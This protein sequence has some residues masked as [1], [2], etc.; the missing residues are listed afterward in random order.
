MR[1]KNSTNIIFGLVLTIISFACNNK[2]PNQLG[3]ISWQYSEDKYVTEPDMFRK[4]PDNGEKGIL[5]LEVEHALGFD[6]SRY[7]MVIDIDGVVYEGKY[8]S[9]LS[10]DDFCFVNDEWC[11]ISIELVDEEKKTI[12]HWAEKESHILSPKI[13]KIRLILQPTID[14]YGTSL[15]VDIDDGSGWNLW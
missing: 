14:N 8:K 13:K 11:M 10:I 1:I 2:K 3:E 9:Q 15:E 6:L 4:C 5:R 7:Y 12:Y